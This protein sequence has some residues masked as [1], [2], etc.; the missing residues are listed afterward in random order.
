MRPFDSM[1]GLPAGS[2]GAPSL[3]EGETV[4]HGVR[5]VVTVGE[6]KLVTSYTSA[7]LHKRTMRLCK[8]CRTGMPACLRV[9]THV[10]AD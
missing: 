1:S 2:N 8:G 6:R 9:R 5:H 4:R 10:R 3:R 7:P